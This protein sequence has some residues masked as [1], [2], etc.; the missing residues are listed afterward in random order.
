MSSVGSAERP[1][2]LSTFDLV[3]AQALMVHSCEDCACPVSE[4]GDVPELTPVAAGA[5]ADES[6]WVRGQEITEIRLDSRHWLLFNPVGNGGVVVL[7]ESAFA[8]FA[9]FR[10]PVTIRTARTAAKQDRADFA[11]VCNRLAALGMVHPAGE[12]QRPQFAPGKVLTAWLHVTNACNLRC[13]YCYISKSN[14]GMSESV[15]RASI[16]A[17]MRSARANG[18]EAVKLK[19][20]GGEASLHSRHLLTMHEYAKALAGE[21]GLNLQATLLSNGVSL[22][23][24]LVQLLKAEQIRVMISLDGVG[25][26]HDVQRPFVSGRPSF[27]FVDATIGELLE[28][29]HPPHLSITITSRNARGVPEVVRYALDRQLSFSLNFFR[30]NDCAATF[31]DLQYEERDMISALLETFEVIKQDMPKWSVLGSILDR[32][33][34]LEPRQH[35]CGVGHDYVVIDQNGKV[36]KCHMEIER[37]LG[38]VFRDDP[39]DLVRRDTTTTLNLLVDEKEGCRDCRWRYWC[40]GG[41]S[42]ATFR[43]TGRYDVKSPNCN[44]YKAIYPQALRLEGLRILKYGRHLEAEAGL[45]EGS[46]HGRYGAARHG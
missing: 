38:D 4:A 22:P 27:R 2:V 13:P 40:S 16:A 20:A 44:I 41:C 28:H 5:M 43:A 18:F 19:Y 35:S 26:Q 34:L 12:S 6:T 17:V 7:N 32:G 46:G 31:A 39:L 14:D 30:D 21:H 23:P 36:A 33:Q 25:D 8:V 37:T 11:D 24:A 45:R 10:Q 1:L 42:V 29:G 3:D 15:W 9:G